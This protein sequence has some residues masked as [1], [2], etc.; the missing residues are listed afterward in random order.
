MDIKQNFQGFS[1][2]MD[3]QL[4]YSKYMILIYITKQKHINNQ[5]LVKH[6]LHGKFI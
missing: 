1:N 4:K 3:L 6:Y 2:T 5:Y